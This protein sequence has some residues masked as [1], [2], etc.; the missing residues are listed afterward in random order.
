MLRA[1]RPT[2]SGPALFSYGFR[3]FFL[4]AGLFALVVIPL[5]TAVFSG[6]VVLAGPFPPVDWH[7]H[8]MLFGYTSAVVAGFLF[9]A[10]PNWTGRMPK[11]GM[12]L[13]FLLV[14]WTLGRLAVAGAG[15]LPPLTVMAV[16]CA[17]LAAIAATICA[18][19]VAGRN[20]RNL[21]VVIPVLLYLAA[22]MVFH[23]EVM[24]SG[25]SDVGR[26][27]G[28]AM[29]IF[30][31]MLIGGRIIPSFTRNWLS[32]R[33]YDRLPRPFGLFDAV[34]LLTGARRCCCG[35]RCRSRRSRVWR[36][37]RWLRCICCA[38]RA[39][40]VCEPVARRCC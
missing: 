11:R 20:W 38:C 2:Y 1:E 16:D 9:T 33:G 19:I 27:L 3:P 39:G 23:L 13:V 17:F 34:C 10:V 35:R 24:R 21:K 36:C 29:V 18:E 40:R 26:R 4:G 25:T 32:A 31:I 14:L 12:P 30:L 28:F 22:N 5:S 15:G 8:E 7:V 6:R 37:W